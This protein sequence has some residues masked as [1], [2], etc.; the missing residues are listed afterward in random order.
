MTPVTMTTNHKLLLTFRTD[1]PD[2]KCVALDVPQKNSN[3]KLDIQ[4]KDNDPEP[5]FE[6]S[7]KSTRGKEMQPPP[8]SFF[9]Q[10]I[11]L[12]LRTQRQNPALHRQMG[13]V[14]TI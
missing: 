11:L 4:G 3:K 6:N 5:G 12:E 14:S 7:T 9:F 13:H 1:A 2:K 10:Q 8:L